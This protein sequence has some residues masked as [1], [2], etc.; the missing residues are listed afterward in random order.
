MLVVL[1]PQRKK[2]STPPHT[3]QLW[4]VNMGRTFLSE[5]Y[6]VTIHLT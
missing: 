2:N 4:L 1:K 3:I 5:Y 6:D